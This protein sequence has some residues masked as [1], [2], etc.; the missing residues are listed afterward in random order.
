[1]H[2]LSRVTM[3]CLRQVG[4]KIVRPYPVTLIRDSIKSNTVK[5]ALTRPVISKMAKMLGWGTKE[6]FSGIQVSWFEPELQFEVTLY[7]KEKLDLLF[8]GA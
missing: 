5:N 1:M 4:T 3:A 2:Q 7:R 6:P 8:L